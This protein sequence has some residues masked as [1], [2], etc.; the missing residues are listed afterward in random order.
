MCN[1]GCLY[2]YGKLKKLFLIVKNIV[3]LV[4]SKT[5]TQMKVSSTQINLKLKSKSKSKWKRLRGNQLKY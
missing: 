4:Y 3:H 2:N 5:G 1:I